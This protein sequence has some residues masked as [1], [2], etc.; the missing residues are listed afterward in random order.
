MLN[1]NEINNINTSADSIVA[2]LLR[3]PG[4]REAGKSFYFSGSEQPDPLRFVCEGTEGGYILE[5][6]LELIC[7]HIDQIDL[8]VSILHLHIVE[9]QL[10]PTSDWK[11]Y[12]FTSSSG[13]QEVDREIPQLEHRV[14]S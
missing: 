13:L 6:E 4:V 14:A 5:L 1:E 9:K 2:I 12:R 8:L 7:E 10:Y 3:F 11:T